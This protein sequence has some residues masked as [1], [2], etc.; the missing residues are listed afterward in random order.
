MFESMPLLVDAVQDLA[1]DRPLVLGLL[2]LLAVAAS[3]VVVKAV[4]GL[5]FRI[6]LIGAVV[7]GGLL[8]VGYLG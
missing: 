4:V 7:L 5:V 1:A 3:V 8:A 2:V 6:A